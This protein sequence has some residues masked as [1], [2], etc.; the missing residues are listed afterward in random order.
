MDKIIGALT[1]PIRR[2]ILALI[3]NR[4]LP[5]GQ[6]AAAFAVTSPT[7]SQH[8]S[9]LREA[10]L[11]AV[12]A[13]GTSRRYRAIPQRLAGMHGALEHE[14]KWVPSD[15][16]PERDLAESSTKLTAFVSVRVDT[17]PELTF[18][19]FTEPAIY[20]RWLGA[21][22]SI[23]ED[24][25]F[26]ATMEWGTEVRGHYTLVCPPHMIVMKWD[27]DDESIPVPGQE[28]TGYLRLLAAPAGGT[29]VEVHQIVDTPEQ[30][31][32]MRAAWSLVLGRLQTGI[33]EAT[34]SSRTMP[35]RPKRPKR[36]K[37]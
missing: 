28:F 16:A 8:L 22:V 6:I 21:P 3:W 7:I 27:L 23:D 14:L 34:D 13:V 20:S 2:E 12:T 24:G 10:G 36:K 18:R 5:A 1:S 4:Q 9:V 30:A 37:A 33:V 17:N 29:I 31:Q 11:V 19:A 26:A 35:P 25:R 32:F 15:D